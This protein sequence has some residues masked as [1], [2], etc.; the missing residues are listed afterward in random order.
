MPYGID[1]SQ[2]NVGENKNLKAK[3]GIPSGAKIIT[4]IDD[5]Y[6]EKNHDL[7]LQ[8]FE[9]V[10]RAN[11][12]LVLM[13]VGS[14]P[15]KQKLQNKVIEL[16]VDER[17]VFIER[18]DNLNDILSVTDMVIAPALYE[19]DLVPILQ[20]Q[21]IGIPVIAS[22]HI[23]HDVAMHDDLMSFIS[24]DHE[25]NIWSKAF[26]NM[27]YQPKMDIIEAR[28]LVA[29]SQYNIER[30]VSVLNGLYQEAKVKLSV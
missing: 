2:D 6:F 11:L 4:Q 9:E 17:V 19:F 27:L 26:S 13:L 18:D 28:E 10:A 7:T 23:P 12:S 21:S 25:M 3:M 1:L 20:A 14:G 29:N 15:L 16:G 24:L 30:N 22:D 5:F 8:L